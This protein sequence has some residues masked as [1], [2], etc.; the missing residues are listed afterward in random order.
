M[1]A[2]F[3]YHVYLKPDKH[4]YSVPFRYRGT[5]L[6]IFFSENTVEIY[7]RNERI[8]LHQRDRREYRYTTLPEH[9]PPQH[10]YRDD[11]SAEK[12]LAWAGTI[13]D[14][15]KTLIE[16]VLASRGHPEQGYKTCLGILNLARDYGNARLARACRTALYYESCSCR[17]VSNLLK[18]NRENDDIADHLFETRLPDHENIR[19]R[20]YYAQE[21]SE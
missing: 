16:A 18:N 17:M 4:Y 8:A 13:G 3:N 10:R 20:D 21:V 12:F 15:V 5:H 6:D 11:W 9:M 1:K 19:G 14:D 7:H 2:Q